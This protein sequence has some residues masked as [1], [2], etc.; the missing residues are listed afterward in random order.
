MEKDVDNE[1]EATVYSDYVRIYRDISPIVD[2]QRTRQRTT[3]CSTAYI[4]LE[5]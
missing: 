1:M 4:G 2:N 5:V 3:W